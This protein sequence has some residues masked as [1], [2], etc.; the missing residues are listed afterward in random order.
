MTEEQEEEQEMLYTL[1]VNLEYFAK[2]TERAKQYYQIGKRAED[3]AD[4]T[5]MLRMTCKLI[6][7]FIT[8][9]FRSKTMSQTLQIMKMGEQIADLKDQLTKWKEDYICLENLKD[10]QIKELQEENKQAKEII[11]MLYSDCYSIAECEDTNLG[12]WE[13]DLAKAEQFLKDSGVEK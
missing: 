2:E 13:D 9:R 1:S 5:K 4:I 7:D 10:S 8:R 3:Y 11:K 12:L 6:K